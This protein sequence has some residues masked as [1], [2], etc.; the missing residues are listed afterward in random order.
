MLSE[1][2]LYFLKSHSNVKLAKAPKRALS[3]LINVSSDFDENESFMN[4]YRSRVSI[5][6]AL[7]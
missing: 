2:S 6:R 3:F 4:Q 5:R 1:S 7:H